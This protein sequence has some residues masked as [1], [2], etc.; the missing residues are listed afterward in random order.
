MVELG[1]SFRSKL[2][3]LDFVLI[4]FLFVNFSDCR[5]CGKQVY[6]GMDSIG[7]TTVS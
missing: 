2:W 1:L 5:D 4:F 3:A 7:F 6:L